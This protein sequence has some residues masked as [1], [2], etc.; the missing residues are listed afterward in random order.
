MESDK[1]YGFHPTIYEKLSNDELYSLY[2][3][4]SWKSLGEGNRQQLLQETV[5]RSAS[6]KGELGACEVRFSNLDS[7]TLGVQSGNTIEMNRSV[8]VND[9]YTHNYNGH[10]IEEPVF[11]SN[12]RALE[13]VLHEDIH[14]WQNQC[15]DG[16]IQCSSA[17]LLSE[18]K[19]NNFTVSVVSG[20]DGKVQLGSHY[21]NGMTE[22][23]GY[24]MYYFQSTERDAHLYSERQTIQIMNSLQ[25]KYGTEKSFL[26][27]QKG[28]IINGYQA[29]FQKGQELFGNNNFD[30]DINQVLVNQYYGTN[31]PVDLKMETAVQK[32]M[33]AS[34]QAQMKAS[35]ENK[36][37][38]MDKSYT[39]VT[40]EDYDNSMRATVNAFYEHALN[41]PSMS[42]EEAIAQTSQ[43]AENYLN[44]MDEINTA[45]ENGEIMSNNDSINAE[46]SEE[47]AGETVTDSAVSDVNDLDNGGIEED[48]GAD[49]DGGVDDDGDIE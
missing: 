21:L 46:I 33:A 13:T 31:V 26:T 20:E 47:N 22:K 32:E 38:I 18:Y 37:D 30:K 11:D 39:P 45:H 23:T 43:M 29:T 36:G 40:V 48:G 2:R 25:E 27:Y 3:E 6:A 35:I 15:I 24:Y 12:M 49:E 7:S 44:T 9:V 17:D 10:L 28:V 16:T 34:Y 5:N 19:S 42:Q 14:A 8:F 4:S 1:G 41:D